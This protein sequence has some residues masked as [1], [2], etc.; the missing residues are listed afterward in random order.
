MS[1]IG[2]M[3]KRKYFSNYRVII[4]LVDFVDNRAIIYVLSIGGYDIN[5]NI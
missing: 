2:V 1:N 5:N 3:N 4:F